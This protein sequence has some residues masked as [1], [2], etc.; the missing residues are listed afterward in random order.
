MKLHLPALV[1]AAVLLCSCAA[2]SLKQTWKS[3]EHT[4]GPVGKVAVLAVEE[5]GTIRQIFE[6]QFAT[7]LEKQGQPALRTQE[8]LT[9][10]EIKDNKE[11]A[12]ARLREAGADSILIVRLVD[13]ATRATTSRVTSNAFVP[14]TTGYGSYAWYDYYTV[15]YRDMNVVHHSLK[16]QLYLDNSLYDLNTGKLLWSGLTKAVLKENTDRLEVVKP[17][18]AHVVTAMRAD[19]FIH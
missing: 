19:G 6:G 1:L 12:A 11:G 8:L 13:M 7:Q 17:L 5:R 9:L 10:P 14:V 15:A 3:P 2:T 18:V 16:Q 4:G